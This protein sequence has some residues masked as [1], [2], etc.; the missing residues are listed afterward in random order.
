[1][2]CQPAHDPIPDHGGDAQEAAAQQQGLEVPPLDAGLCEARPV[3]L[4]AVRGFVH[5]RD[6]LEVEG[7]FV[8]Q[9]VLAVDDDGPEDL[10]EGLDGVV[11]YGDEWPGRRGRY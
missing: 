9:P 7:S 11:S 8:L 6:V 1:M 10:A 4:F 2:L 5:V 3:R